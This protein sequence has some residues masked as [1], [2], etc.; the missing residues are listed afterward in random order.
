MTD[1]RRQNDS[2][3]SSPPTLSNT[4]KP[5]VAAAPN[6]QGKGQVGFLK[7]WEESTPRNAVAKPAPRL[8][9]D[10]FTSLLVLSAH[11][12]FKPAI[13]VNYYLYRQRQRW[14]L[15]PISPDEWNSAEKQRAYVGQCV[16]HEDSTWSITPS[17]NVSS[18]E[19]IASALAEFSGQFVDK[20]RTT[21]PLENELPFYVAELPY[22]Q[23]LYA[24][25]LGRSLRQSIA[26]GR[27]AGLASTRWLEQLPVNTRELLATPAATRTDAEASQSAKPQPYGSDYS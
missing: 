22:F 25:A 9:A 18:N 5:V 11:F 15:S 8:L 4:S 13:D 20:L 16:M 7:D 23:R 21:L 10:Y 2:D 6:P 3:S 14:L 12:K 17:K 1:C 27:Q 19:Y 24:A 26:T